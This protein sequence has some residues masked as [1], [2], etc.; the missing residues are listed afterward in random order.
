[1]HI[2]FLSVIIV[3]IIQVFS[4][5]ED[6]GDQITRIYQNLIE[7]FGIPVRE[8]TKRM[9]E[10]TALD[11]LPLTDMQAGSKWSAA[12]DITTVQ[13]RTRDIIQILQL[14]TQRYSSPVYPLSDNHKNKQYKYV[15]LNEKNIIH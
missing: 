10:K 6:F 11:F 4:V 3:D 8:M 15:I 7:S 14:Q 13:L 1:M 2:L 9:R 12:K 5:L